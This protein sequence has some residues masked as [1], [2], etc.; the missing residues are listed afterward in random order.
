VFLS[1]NLKL[2]TQR[3]GKN[4]RV[5][6]S[7]VLRETNIYLQIKCRKYKLNNVK[8]HNVYLTHVARKDK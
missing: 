7:K 3:E 2:L 5:F 6:Q 8:F 4:F 1:V